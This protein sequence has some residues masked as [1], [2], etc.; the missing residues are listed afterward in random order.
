[1]RREVSMTDEP[2]TAALG[3]AIE[4][5]PATPEDLDVLG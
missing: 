1:M 2:A 5:V 3:L 4:L